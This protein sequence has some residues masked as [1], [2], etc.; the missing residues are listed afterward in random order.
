MS[1]RHRHGTAVLDPALARTGAREVEVA[2]AR[3]AR[4]RGP[5]AH[6]EPGSTPWRT[7]LRE[8]VMAMTRGRLEPWRPV[9][10]VVARA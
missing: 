10:R 9:T 4:R 3:R 8:I 6:R 5:G 7:G 2:P 1:A